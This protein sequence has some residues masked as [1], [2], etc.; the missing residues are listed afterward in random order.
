[1]FWVGY[2]EFLQKTQQH[3]MPNGRL[4][5]GTI[6][7]KQEPSTEYLELMDGENPHFNLPTTIQIAYDTGFIPLE[8]QRSNDDEMGCF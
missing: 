7:W 5:I 8:I 4:L 2:R 1:M 6:F 3:L